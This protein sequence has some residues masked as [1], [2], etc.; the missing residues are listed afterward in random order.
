MKT[1]RKDAT[2]HGKVK[3]NSLNWILILISIL[4]IVYFVV[5]DKSTRLYTFFSFFMKLFLMSFVIYNLFIIGI[6][7]IKNSKQKSKAK[8]IFKRLLIVLST[9]MSIGYATF[10]LSF[11]VFLTLNIHS[12][13]TDASEKIDYI[14]VLGAGLNGEIPSPIL[15][16]RLDKTIEVAKLIPDI[17]I[18][19]CGGK[20]PGEDI[21]EA[22]AMKQYLCNRGVK[23]GRIITEEE[24]RNTD[25]NISNA[26]KIIEQ[27]NGGREVLIVTSSFH[28]MRSKL[29]AKRYQ[30]NSHS[31]AVTSKPSSYHYYLRE[32]FAV[33]YYYVF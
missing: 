11:I 25:E 16:D 4:G 18:I 28:M 26:A 22:I 30:L 13:K 21:E 10:L 14:I 33:V 12:A 31:A 1:A 29:I 24:S 3:S 2:V 32:Y 8:N 17:Y 23:P 20:S 27:Q 7:T 9:T 5:L 6:K 15:R 19:V